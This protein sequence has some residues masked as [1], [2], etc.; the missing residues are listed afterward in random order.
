Y[1][2]ISYTGIN[3]TWNVPEGIVINS[4]TNNGIEDIINVTFNSN[5]AGGSIG[6]TATNECGTS[7]ERS[8]SF[9]QL[10]P[11]AVSG[12][13]Q[14]SAGNCPDRTYI[15]NVAAMPTNALSL[16][17]TVP[18]GAT[19][20]SGQGT[21]T[22]TVVYPNEAIVGV[23]S[24]I[25]N[26]GC[27]NS[28]V[29]RTFAV[30]LGGCAPQSF[31]KSNVKSSPIEEG[32]TEKFEIKI[33]PNPSTANFKLQTLSKNVNEILHVRVIDNLGREYKRLQMK[34]GETISIGSDLKAGSY[35]IEVVQ[36]KTKIVKRVLKF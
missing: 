15:Y 22:I 11:G 16:E 24:A 25:G 36:G 26:N 32:I 21:T 19:I 3:Y 29:A 23:I 1:S 18:A 12:I 4:H 14:I 9:A 13:L 30:K 7:E 31:V 6:V 34:P 8:L 28:P 27:G 33:Y 5:Y 17:W 20:I 10:S 35:L 2:V